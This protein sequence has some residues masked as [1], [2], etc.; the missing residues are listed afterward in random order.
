[1]V[2]AAA[3]PSEI[4]ALIKV[5]KLKLLQTCLLRIYP[6]ILVIIIGF[7]LSILNLLSIILILI[8]LWSAPFAYIDDVIR[9][10]INTVADPKVNPISASLTVLIS[11][12][13]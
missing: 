13:S 9:V 6:T 11:V 10:I 7:L 3:E 12:S 4:I 1:M 8:K 2:P 5:I